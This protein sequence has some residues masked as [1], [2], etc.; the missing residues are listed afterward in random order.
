MLCKLCKW[1][2]TSQWILCSVLLCSLF[3]HFLVSGICCGWWFSFFSCCHWKSLSFKSLSFRAFS[4]CWRNNLR[5]AVSKTWPMFLHMISRN[6]C[7]WWFE[8]S[9]WIVRSASYVVRRTK[10]CDTR[11]QNGKNPDSFSQ[12]E[13]QSVLKYTC[14]R[15]IIFT[16]Y[17]TTCYDHL[18]SFILLFCPFST[19]SRVNGFF[20]QFYTFCWTLLS[21]LRSALSCTSQLIAFVKYDSSGRKT[22]SKTVP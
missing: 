22:L 8:R 21:I 18:F 6:V 9:L 19:K 14:T 7:C 2:P 15:T 11:K 12:G 1:L 3:V 17:K 16:P 13:F 20:C 10:R 4:F 5:I